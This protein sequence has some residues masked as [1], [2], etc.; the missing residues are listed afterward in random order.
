LKISLAFATLA[1]ATGCKSAPKEVAP[2]QAGDFFEY[3]FTTEGG[4]ESRYSAQIAVERGPTKDT[5]IIRATPDGGEKPI[6]VDRALDAGKRIKMH[7]LGQLWLPPSLR[8]VDAKTRIGRVKG[9][10]KWGGFNVFVVEENPRSNYYYEK[11]TGFLVG[12][13]TPLGNGLQ[14][15][16]LSK[17]SV[18]ELTP[19]A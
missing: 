7:F 13:R 16:N 14:T 9:E 3:S 1:L 11:A 6:E 8:T 4:G 2:I 5:F 12:Y 15:A 10:E 19:G 18:R 17:S